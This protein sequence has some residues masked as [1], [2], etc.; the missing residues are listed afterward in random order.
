MVYYYNLYYKFMS[1][2]FLIL[3]GDLSSGI[4]P[5]DLSFPGCYPKIHLNGKIW[6]V[7]LNDTNN[8]IL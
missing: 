2:I 1:C 6:V 7:I 5:V 8:N 4:E 3:F